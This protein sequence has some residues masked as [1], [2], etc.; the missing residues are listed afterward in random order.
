MALVVEVSIAS[1]SSI[2]RS[3]SEVL[4]PAGA[5]DT[6][7]EGVEDEVVATVAVKGSLA[8]ALCEED[9]GEE[10]EATDGVDRAAFVVPTETG[11][12]LGDALSLGELDDSDW[13]NSSCQRRKGH[14][15]SRM[16]PYFT[17]ATTGPRSS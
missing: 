1:S 15:F 16:E 4:K 5:R 17:L 11:V 6:E 9:V 12:E 7:V 8:T 10:A 14:F 13:A 3:K 2:I